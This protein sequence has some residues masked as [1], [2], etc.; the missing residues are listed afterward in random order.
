MS[1]SSGMS[2]MTVSCMGSEMEVGEALDDIFKQIQ[3]NINN[4]HSNIRQ[5]AMIDEQ[6][7]EFI[8]CAK[9]DLNIV[10]FV[11]DLTVLFKE[12]KSVSKQ[13]L[14]KPSTDEEKK[15]LKELKE[16]DKREREMKKR[17]EEHEKE[18][19]GRY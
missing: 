19:M 4:C 10:N 2:N 16:K 9:L 12:L 8:E 18:R 15:E 5:L 1:V 6:S 3:T 11:N 14:G 13:I 7:I 17:E